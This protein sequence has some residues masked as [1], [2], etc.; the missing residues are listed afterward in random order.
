MSSLIC[1]IVLQKQKDH[2]FYCWN[3]EKTQKCFFRKQIK[4]QNQSINKIIIFSHGNGCD[5]FTFS[6]KLYEYAEM[7]GCTIVCYDYA[8]YGLTKGTPSEENCYD[9]IEAVTNHYVENEGMNNVMIIGQSLG[10]GV[11]VHY[12][13]ETNWKSPIVLMSTYK[14]IGRV[15][16]DSSITE[17]SF[18]H[19]MF[20]TYNKIYKLTCPVKIIHSTNDQIINVSHGKDL[21]DEFKNPL[22]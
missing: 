21:Y 1:C 14:S 20:C 16:C 12:A 11:V 17:S 13:N 5:I 8:G 2:H 15:V 6:E 22:E 9:A 10:T 3:H 7:F 18:K 19:N 4:K